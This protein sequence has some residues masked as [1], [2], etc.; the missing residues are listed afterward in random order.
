MRLLVELLVLIPA[1]MLI[2]F[3]I[4]TVQHYVAFGVHGYGFSRDALGLASFEGG[5]LGVLLGLPTGL[6]TYFVA[7][8]RRPNPKVIAETV[9]GSMIGGCLLGLLF[10]IFSAGLTP[11]LTFGLGRWLTDRNNAAGST[12]EVLP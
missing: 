4:A 5:F 12:S 9:A 3:S 10:Y 1:S 7:L 8:R 2:G 11:F 6:L